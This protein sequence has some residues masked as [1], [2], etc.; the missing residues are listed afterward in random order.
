[1]R[2]A[3]VETSPHGGLLHYAVQLADALAERG[4]EVD[5][6]APEDNELADHSGPAR[7]RACLTP[8]VR[9]SDEPRA[10]LA[11]FVRRL[12]I[13]LRLSR[14]WGR[15]I[16]E[17]RRRRYDALILAEDLGL[18]L[19]AGA[20]LVLTARPG[21][22]ALVDV[23]HNV[24]PFNR[25]SGEDLWESSPLM[26]ALLRRVYPRF[27]LVL[28]HGEKSRTDFEE[29]WPPSRLAVVP[30]GDERIF[31]GDPPPP[32][33]EERILFFGD[34]RK[35]KGLSVLIEAFDQL[36]A[37]RPGVRLTIAGTPVPDVDP[38]AVR[39]WAAAHG[40][41]VRIIDHYVP[42]EQVRELFGGARVV[43]T[44]YLIGYQSGVAHV[45]MT[46]ARAVVASD[47]GDLPS[48]VADGETGRVVPAGDS[49][50]LAAALEEIVSDSEL[51][52]RLGAE[53]RR[54][55]LE[56]S[57]WEKVAERVEEELEALPGR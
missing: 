28:V 38:D 3:V 21:R 55:V 33:R 37:R 44:P 42:V 40:E 2:I 14:A 9:S 36:V 24:R 35:V 18:S 32:A 51:A 46:M 23:C 22:P 11:G 5:I 25:W 41:R 31:A 10:G 7:M 19:A 53:G 48:A 4:H 17:A 57:G 27:D 52:E 34:W 12:G 43:A 50:A 29:S 45:A 47:V 16:W 1:M 56:R 49:H 54:R 8:P 20:A 15:I 26:L 13:A 6:L 30:H 39:R